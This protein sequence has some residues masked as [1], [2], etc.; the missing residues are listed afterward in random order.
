MKRSSRRLL[1][2]LLSIIITVGAV[3]FLCA[4]LI[5]GTL[6]NEKYMLKFLQNDTI[7]QYCYDTYNERISLLAENSGI[8][9]RVFEVAEN[10]SGY[11]ESAVERFFSGGKTEIYTVDK[12]N[13]YESLIKEYL[14]GVGQAYDETAV[15]NTAEKAA[16]IYSESFGIKNAEALR[17]FVNNTKEIYPK[18]VSVSF[19][20]I[21]IPSLLCVFMFTKKNRSLKYF[22]MSA[23]STGI[24]MILISFICLISRVGKGLSITPVMYQRGISNAVTVMLVSALILGII[25]TF[26]AVSS[27][28]SEAEKQSKKYD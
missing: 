15:H 4:T 9:I 3:M 26:F 5:R 20:L 7:E 13:T 14:D 28:Y 27:A 2:T 19:M 12:I 16:I 22:Y 8:P 23:S 6:C 24:S 11:N 21:L 18:F 17:N 1:C 10:K 25:I